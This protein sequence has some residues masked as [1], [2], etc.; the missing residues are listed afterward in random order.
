M[1]QTLSKRRGA[2]FRRVRRALGKTQAV[3]ARAFGVHETTISLWESAARPLPDY[4]LDQLL[5][6]LIRGRYVVP[7]GVSVIELQ[8]AIEEVR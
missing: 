1:T 4:R 8:R 5:L 2:V 3:M 6:M 7:D